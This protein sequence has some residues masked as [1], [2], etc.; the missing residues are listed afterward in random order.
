MFSSCPPRC[1]DC[2]LLSAPGGNSGAGSGQG[3]AVAV[4]AVLLQ[5]SLPAVANTS[6]TLI[7]TL[8]VGNTPSHPKAL[9]LCHVPNQA[10]CTHGILKAW[11]HTVTSVITG[12]SILSA[13]NS[14]LLFTRIAEYLNRVTWLGTSALNQ[15]AESRVI[16]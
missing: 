4:T 10:S 6:C 13:Q 5:V 16:P 11:L 8:L 3:T 7:L 9:S 15:V 14:Q 2:P 1:T 12:K